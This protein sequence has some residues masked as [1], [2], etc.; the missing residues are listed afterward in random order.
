MPRT[1][2]SRSFATS[3]CPASAGGPS[4]LR[5]GRPDSSRGAGQAA[6][7]RSLA[8]LPGHTRHPVALAPRDD[9]PTL[10]VPGH[11]SKPPGAGPHGGRPGA[12]PGAGESPVGIR[13]H[14]RRVPQARGVG[15][16][17]LGT[18][19]SAPSSSRTGTPPPRPN[20]DAVPACAGRRNARLRFP[21]RRDRRADPPVRPV[22]DRTRS[23]SGPPGRRHCPPDRRLGHPG[24]P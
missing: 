18:D 9:P 11:R 7:P 16:G 21:H 19:N 4:P 2:R 24:G 22:R 13:A 1:W 17:Y 3:C 12:T 20:L 23:P 15:V 5:P 8:H 6:P 14:C 10:D